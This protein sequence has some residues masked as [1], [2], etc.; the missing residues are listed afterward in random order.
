MKTRKYRKNGI[1]ILGISG[2][3]E[4]SHDA[5]AV[6]IDVT[7]ETC[8]IV[9][10]LEEEKV[11]GIKAAY[12][13]LPQNSIKDLLAQNCLAPNDID[14]IAFGWDYIEIYK[15]QNK[16]IPLTN[17]ELTSLLFNA[18]GVKDIPIAYFKH[19]LCHA[20]ASYYTSS[21]D[22]SI[23]VVADGNGED[24]ATSFWI[25]NENELK[26]IEKSN[27]KS[28]FGFLYEA[29]N[30]ILGF[31]VNESGKTMGLAP[32]G[33]PYVY[34][35][36]INKFFKNGSTELN[37]KFDYYFNK[38]NKDLP[39][40]CFYWQ[41]MLIKTWL[42]IFSIE[43]DIKRTKNKNNSFYEIDNKYKNLAATIQFVLEEK[44]KSKI[45][46]IINQ[47]NI[48]NISISGGVGL[49]CT[50]NGKILDMPNVNNIFINPSAGDSG[51]SLGAAL[52]L[53]KD[54]SYCCR[55]NKPFNPYIGTEYEDS[56]I[57]K[58]L[59]KENIKY[60]KN[61]NA[62]ETMSRLLCSN[63]TISL[64][65]G[66]NEWGPRALGNRTIA[67]LPVKN[68]LN[69]INNSIKK[70]ELGRPLGP[71]LLK[72]D[73]TL[74]NSSN[75]QYGKY[76]NIAYKSDI[77]LDHHQSIK[78]IDSSYRPQFVEEADNKI[79]YDQLMQLKHDYGDSII[80]NTSFNIQ[81]PIVYTPIQA[82]HCFKNAP[83]DA[84]IFNNSI[85]IE[86]E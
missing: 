25:G 23:V 49:N 50:M 9:G 57:E 72:E 66:R 60:Y 4:R 52:L 8:E 22:K 41:E 45:A 34:L 26:L 51:V 35:D 6:L 13:S 42:L 63:K 20:A 78:H 5:S 37:E 14:Y 65:Q 46:Q 79:Y 86:R 19:H 55:I 70:R 11:I 74:L 24:E 27:I 38:I 81:T 83:I 64:F 54:L 12:D 28:S 69:Y 67:S 47:T 77:M 39:S 3:L 84:L 7:K 10:A 29:M 15:S 75:K 32:F 53:A 62:S 59:K 58:I 56:E 82:L 44:I 31:N 33:N 85:I 21:F 17:S 2:W 18:S 76:M 16:K 40:C 80:I 71:S 30:I 43:L 36:K 1:L 61:E 73:S 68:R 48:N